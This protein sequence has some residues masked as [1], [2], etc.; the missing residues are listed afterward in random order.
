MASI[1]RHMLG[2][3]TLREPQA[4]GVYWETYGPA[5]TDSVEVAIA[6]TRHATPGNV[7][8]RL[9]TRLG[10]GRRTESTVTVRWREPQPGRGAMT[11]PSNTVP[12]QGRAVALDVSRLLPGNYT[13]TVSTTLLA[14]RAGTATSSRDFT[15]LKT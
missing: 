7:F 8:Q 15:I 11:I 14:R 4:V 12:I 13:L 9:G 3:L 10:L 6:I 5:P 1:L 2:S